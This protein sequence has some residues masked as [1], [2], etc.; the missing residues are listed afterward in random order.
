LRFR[1]PRWAVRA[2]RE[3]RLA[4]ECFVC[5]G[6]SAGDEARRQFLDESQRRDGESGFHI[7]SAGID[8]FLTRVQLAR[9]AERTLDL[10]YFIFRGDTT[11]ACSPKSCNEPPIAGP[12][13]DPR[14]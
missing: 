3:P 5:P 7:L 10:Q 2:F 4:E 12:G 14:R 8:G 9:A 1:F 11:G 13:A 6:A